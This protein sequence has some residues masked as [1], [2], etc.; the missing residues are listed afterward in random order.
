MFLN[1]LPDSEIGIDGAMIINVT[2]HQ[3]KERWQF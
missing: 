3:N 1:L 2:F